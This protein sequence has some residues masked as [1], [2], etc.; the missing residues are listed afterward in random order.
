MPT[1]I[2]KRSLLL[3]LAVSAVTSA[4][5]AAQDPFVGEW[6]LNPSKS[7]VIDQMKVE[8]LGGNK[9]ELDFGGGPERIVADSTDQ[10]TFYG[11]MLS[12]TVVGGDTWKV[13]RKKD[14][15]TLLTG[16]WKLS[17]DGNTLT[18]NYTEF[19][20]NGSSSTVN[21][22]YTRTAA[23]EGFAGTWESTIAMMESASVLQI[24]P[25]EGNGLSFIHSSEDVTRNVKFDGKD[26]P[27][28]GRRGAQGWT[29]SARREDERTLEITDKLKGTIMRTEQ[30]EL[31]PDLKTLT[32]T[33]RPVGQRD[34]NVFVFE[35][36]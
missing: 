5:W 24:R 2:S 13:V 21:Y 28:A 8:S 11:T 14:G 26:Y 10:P 18:D 1:L 22:L 35:R 30:I 9:Y 15:R 12:V 31:S 23:G 17:P 25:Y 29:T 7:K 19:G 6:K 4:L 32:R 33:A 20:S 34:P 3:L 36:Q 16:I 27:N